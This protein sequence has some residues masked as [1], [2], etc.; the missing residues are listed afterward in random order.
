MLL[1]AEK[2]SSANV[3]LRFLSF[4]FYE[5]DRKYAERIHQAAAIHERTKMNDNIASQVLIST[6]IKL[7]KSENGG[8]EDGKHQQQS[9]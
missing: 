8:N 2:S 4:V 9:V 3:F 7:Y 6:W 5:V 1:L